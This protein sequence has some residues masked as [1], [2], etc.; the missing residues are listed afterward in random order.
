MARRTLIIAGLGLLTVALFALG[1]FFLVTQKTTSPGESGVRD[2]FSAFFPFGQGTTPTNTTGGT[3]GGE[4]P[5][6]KVTERFRQVSAEPTAGAW[7]VAGSSTTPLSI[8]F[9]E[10]ATG[11]VF[12]TPVDSYQEI[13]LSNTTI[14]LTQELLSVTDT[15]FVLRSVPDTESVLNFFGVLNATS[16]MQSVHTSP[17]KSFERVQVAGDGLTL[18]TVNETAAGSEVEI[19]KPDGTGAKTI[20]LS[21]IRSWVPLVAESRFFLASAPSSGASGFM[22]EIKTNGSLTKILGDIGGLVALPSPT[23]RFVLY[24]SAEGSLVTLA[25]LDTQTGENYLAPLRTLA[26]KCVWISEDTPLVFCGVSDPI[27]AANTRL[28]DDWLLGKTAFNDS[29][30][31]IRPVENSA[32]SLGRLQEMAGGAFDMTNI[33][34]SSDGR[35]ALFNNKN[36][37]SLWSLD[38]TRTE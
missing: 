28:P 9:M 21:P 35:Y 33:T 30:W 27:S 20:L 19:M 1:Y 14:P 12:E 13:R 18:L 4:Q 24:S 2:F 36:D 23:G 34:V 11:H 26:S 22:Y 15:T 8:R 37:L 31:L 7:F 16:S 3:N 25:M 38:L 6:Q 32:Q 10:R 29:A 5:A 17:L